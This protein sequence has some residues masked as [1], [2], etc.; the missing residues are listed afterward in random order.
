MICRYIPQV[1]DCVLGVITDKHSENF[2]VDINAPFVASLPV[3]AFEGA[4]RRS[5]PNL[6]VSCILRLEPSTITCQQSQSSIEL[7]A[8]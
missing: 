4:T 3:L 2:G 6:Q 5:R 1:G 7:G 8:Y